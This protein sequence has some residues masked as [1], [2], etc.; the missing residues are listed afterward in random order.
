METMACQRTRGDSSRQCT[1]P[2]KAAGVLYYL[3]RTSRGRPPEGGTGGGLSG[4]PS[5]VGAPGTGARVPAGGCCGPGCGLR[6]VSAPA[7]LPPAPDVAGVPVG[8]DVSAGVGAPAEVG[9]AASASTGLAVGLRLRVAL[10][11]AGASGVSAAGTSAAPPSVAA[12][13]L[14]RGLVVRE[15]GLRGPRVVPPS[16]FSGVSPSVGAEA[17]PTG[18][19]DDPLEERP[20]PLSEAP[21]VTPPFAG[22]AWVPRPLGPSSSAG[23]E[24]SEVSLSP[25]LGTVFRPG[26]AARAAR[27]STTSPPPA[28]AGGLPAAWPP[29][30]VP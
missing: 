30:E 12:G 7:S 5:V 15:A 21:S 27:K 8:V 26:R 28:G 24:A 14:R 16:S 19:T 13:V 22:S 17:S 20:R 3:M 11:L 6:P 1:W 2:C 18:D 4:G 10:G 23:R 9:A 25:G 29:W